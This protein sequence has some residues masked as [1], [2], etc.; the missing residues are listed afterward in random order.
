MGG[1]ARTLL[2]H[3][4]AVLGVALLVGAIYV[5]Q[6]EFRG[7]KIADIQAALGELP[8]GKLVLS[9]LW[10]LLSY[11][12]LTFYDRLGTIYAGRAV[13]YGKVAFASFCAYSLAHNLGFA[14]VSG[15]AVRYR[16]YANWGLTPLQIGKVVAFCSLT[17]GLGG[18]VLAGS[19]L[20]IE[21]DAIPFFGARVSPWVMYAIG[22]A[23]WFVVAAY[24]TLSRVLGT[25]RVF[26]HEIELPGWR[27]AVLQVLLATVDVMTTAAIFF[28]LLPDVPGLT[29]MRFLGIYLASYTAGLVAN[30]PGGLGVFDTAI[31]LGLAPYMQ[32]PEIVGAIVVFRL[33]YYIIP[34][35]LAGALFAGN[36]M[37][38]RGRGLLK[39]AA[40]T[41]GVQAIGRWSQPDFA[42]A[43]GTGAVALC[44]A[45]L[46][47]VGMLQGLGD[48]GLWN[49]SYFWM[50][51]EVG[52]FLPSL[53]GAA[54]LVMAAGL[55]QRVSLAWTGSIALLLAGAVFVALHGGLLW[56][57]V[58]L[59]LTAALLAP[60]RRGFYRPARLFS[61]T[62]RAGTVLPLVMLLVCVVA[63][64]RFEP[65]LRW[66]DSNGFWEV[67]FS[68]N[69][70]NSL[71]ASVALVVVLAAAALLRLLLP[72]RVEAA[73]WDAATQA[74]YAALGGRMPGQADGVIWGE[75]GRAAIVFRRIGTLLLALGDPV[76]EAGDRVSA[77]WRLRD[78][79]RQDGLNPAV[80]WAGRDLLRVY[81]DLGLTALP[82]GPDGMPAADAE[83]APGPHAE[84]F[85]VCIA[86]RDLPALLPLLPAL[87]RD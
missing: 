63:L 26:G 68:A 64:A 17:F 80:W 54:L 52:E 18:L 87:V 7:L 10:T 3:A 23:L 11:G 78:L 35:F 45:L 20:F 38:L 32:A 22:A 34:L 4:P 16:L 81:G 73:A 67:I 25:I 44:G 62:L 27:M 36:E 41:R 12:I 71:R 2:R 39:P 84:R 50:V 5:L 31:L 29:Y 69:V 60:F 58:V 30:L 55:T 24:V 57:S 13:S 86:E 14:A 19:I 9:F 48:A 40:R 75:S 82:L 85:L 53:V 72:G 43:A 66:L 6:R 61:G 70:P 51:G 21:P 74:R 77:I 49:D 76:G 42:A 56:V 33:Y 47:S 28:V 79:A 59:A 37:L 8:T 65:R 1:M 46:M 15:A 83:D